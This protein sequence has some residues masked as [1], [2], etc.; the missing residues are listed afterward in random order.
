MTARRSISTVLVWLCAAV[1]AAATS[2]P[3]LAQRE[4]VFDKS[5]G[6]EGSGNGQL[7]RPGALAVNDE[8][9]DVYVID[10]GNGRVEIF[11][12]NGEYVSRFNGSGAPTGA[13]SWASGQGNE[14]S[15]AID[16][17]TDPADPSKGDVY[18]TDHVDNL[19]DKFTPNGTY[20]GQVTGPA[21]GSPFVDEGSG[22]H[23]IE[24]AVDPSG[25][26]WVQI[27]LEI[28]V[29]NDAIANEY[30]S[31]VQVANYVSKA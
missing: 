4:N 7:V 8:T 14:G 25:R 17:S 29:F 22:R 20:I 3:A 5:F 6:S 11:N 18:V 21:P 2:A 26:L 13:F 31:Q 28:D 30:V 16:N 24:I 19:I 10:R 12:E 27:Y 9:G 1:L 15:I 23:V